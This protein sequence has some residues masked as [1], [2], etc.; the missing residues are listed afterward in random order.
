MINCVSV[1]GRFDVPRTLT[2]N[3]HAAQDHKGVIMNVHKI[4]ESLVEFVITGC[5]VITLASPFV[6][7]LWDVP[8]PTST[9]IELISRPSHD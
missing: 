6:P 8:A 5:A 9:K 4:V 3:D 7:T 1:R 2:R